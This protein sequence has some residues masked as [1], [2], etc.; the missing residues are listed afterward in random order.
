ML[1]LVSMLNNYGPAP[2]ERMTVFRSIYK[3]MNNNLLIIA[4]LCF[5]YLQPS[6]ADT[7]TVV[8]QNG[9]NGYRGCEDSYNFTEEPEVNHGTDIEA[10]TFNCIP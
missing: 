8:L 6:H 10:H 1:L 3:I 7:T 2:G 4:V 9:L 5:F